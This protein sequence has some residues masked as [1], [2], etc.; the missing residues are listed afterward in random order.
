MLG[1]LSMAR[2]DAA[3]FRSVYYHRLQGSFW[4]QLADD[5]GASPTPRELA[6]ASIQDNFQAIR[7]LG[8]DTVTIG[9][10]D[11]DNWVSQ[12]GGGF[13]YDPKDSIAARP[14]FAVA[15]E[16]ILRLAEADKLKVIFAI[17]LSEYRRSSD[18]GATRAGLADEYGSTSKPRGAFDY[19]HCLI[20]PTAYYGSLSTT[21][22][23]KIGLADGPVRSHVGDPRV[24]GWVFSGEWN[25]N[26][27]STTSKIAVH[28]HV[29][30][31]YWNFF[32]NLVHFNG[33]NNAFAGTY[34]I[35]QPA[36]G[37]AQVKNIKAFKQWFAPGSGIEEPDLIGVEFYGPEG[38][39]LASTYKDLDLMVEAMEAADTSGFRGDFA[40]PA[41]RIFLGE[42]NT[43]Q[44]ATPT[45]NQYFQDVLQ[46]MTDRRLAGIQFWVTDTLGTRMTS[47][48]SRRSPL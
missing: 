24:V 40:I 37:N 11:S 16:I 17:G 20:D 18:G 38:Y 48:G 47:K 22:L 1:V 21:G 32:Y 15:Q 26:V 34:L 2:A 30:K 46:V 45:I 29:F 35:G 10:P 42:G 6:V 9:L 23:A 25:V 19:L 27:K 33:A 12:H 13:S 41:S 44:T 3:S 14:Q 7:S 36:S 31:K 8:F 5:T 39:D 43:L 28:E 4:A